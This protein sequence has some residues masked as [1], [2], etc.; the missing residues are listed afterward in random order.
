MSRF[1]KKMVLALGLKLIALAAPQAQISLHAQNVV[2]KAQAEQLL[3]KAEKASS[4]IEYEEFME[5]HR[6]A[7][8]ERQKEFA[9]DLWTVLSNNIQ[10]VQAAEKRGSGAKELKKIF[11]DYKKYNITIDRNYFCA[12]AGLG[13]LLQT[14]EENDYKEYKLLFDCL[15]NPNSC[16]QIIKDFKSYFGDVKETR[17][18]QKKLSDIY[19]NNPYAVCI[20]FPRSRSNSRSGY[21]YVTVFS[22]A[23]A[24]DT[25]V[26]GDDV[27]KG[28]TARFN[29]T[30][31]SNTEDYFIGGKNRGYV[32]D[33]SSMIGNYQ[34][35]QMFQEFLET[36]QKKL[37]DLRKYL[38]NSVQKTVEP[39]SL[40]P[41]NPKKSED[42][43]WK[44]VSRSVSPER[45]FVRSR[46][47]RLS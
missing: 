46:D 35:F 26:D 8:V 13:S 16:S 7:I 47:S 27:L 36:E 21:H 45:R 30:A 3:A 39:V 32:F 34:V 15:A 19:S 38:E 37:E 1:A 33:I 40:L 42:I 12:S 22:N 44:E 4:S 14:I 9:L 10:K 28:K 41:E 23:T 24:V 17:D 43:F 5:K 31:I 18:I 20:V 29:R 6:E 2:K 25:L 11:G